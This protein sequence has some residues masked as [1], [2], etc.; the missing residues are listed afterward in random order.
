MT[1]RKTQLK[2]NEKAEKIISRIKYLKDDT[3][4]IG[5]FMELAKEWE[6]EYARIDD[7]V[8]Q[9]GRN[10]V[11]RWKWKI[12]DGDENH[13]FHQDSEGDWVRYKAHVDHVKELEEDLEDKKN[14]IKQIYAFVKTKLTL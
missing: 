4:D 13:D 3:I 10:D 9:K 12:A 8:L 14:Y 5:L 1:Q 11:V 7:P 6:F 2:M